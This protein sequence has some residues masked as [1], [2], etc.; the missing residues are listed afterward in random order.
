LRVTSAAKN[1]EHYRE[2]RKRRYKEQRL[3]VLEKRKQYYQENKSKIKLRMQLTQDRRRSRD[4][5]RRKLDPAF[6]AKQNI[7]RRLR[8]LL[9]Q[10]K[11]ESTVKFLG[12][13]VGCLKQW[14]SYQ[15]EPGMTWDNY[16]EWHIDHVR[17]CAS[18]DLTDPEQQKQCFHW[19][20]LQPLWA[21]D[22]LKK[23]VRF[24]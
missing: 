22:N 11:H 17:P 8:K 9:S 6:R 15:F 18:F 16:G 21:V 3:V 4:R 23:G 1:N 20:N 24:N 2:N 12:C 10:D 19:T 13:S 14:L 5:A 7:S